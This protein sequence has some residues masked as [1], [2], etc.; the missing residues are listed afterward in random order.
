[1]NHL[2]EAL[3]VDVGVVGRH[4]GVGLDGVLPEALGLQL[5]PLALPGRLGLVLLL[6]FVGLKEEEES[7]ES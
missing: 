5:A 3:E 6:V 4:A 2:G 1:M 7:L